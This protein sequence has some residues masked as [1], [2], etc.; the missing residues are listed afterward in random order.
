[1]PSKLISVAIPA[2]D[3]PEYLERALKSLLQQSYRPIEVI[4]S[5][6][7]SPQCLSALVSGF[8]LIE[9]AGFQ[10]K[11]FKQSENLGYYWNLEFA[12]KQ[13]SGNY[14][15]MLDHD[16]WIIDRN[17]FKFCIEEME[18][19]P[20]CSFCIS[21]T[22][23]EYS[24][25]PILDINYQ[26]WHSINGLHFLEKYLFGALHPVRSSVVMR[27]DLLKELNYF[28]FFI[29]KDKARLL[30][31]NPDEAFVSLALL[32]QSGSVSMCGRAMV[33][34]GEPPDSLS[35]R[36]DWYYAAGNKSFIQYYFLYKYFKKKGCREGVFIM[37]KN[38]IF[39]HPVPS[40]NIKLLKLFS[41]EK[42]ATIMMIIGAFYFRIRWISLLPYRLILKL[43]YFN[44]KIF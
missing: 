15:L 43:K 25:F 21:N 38:L 31:I 35:K 24:P 3:Q 37:I 44:S 4:V 20:N 22:L 14:L 7:N 5:D 26:N 18:Q 9:E 33:V 12:A 39:N 11:Y 36:R 29:G 27:L 17:Y 28:D 1:M 23:L 13:A 6:D 10:I 32:S 8:S 41:Y 2:Y 42:D 19:N 30:G 34:R 40:I 16:D